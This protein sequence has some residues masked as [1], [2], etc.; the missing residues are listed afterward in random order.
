MD[1]IGINLTVNE[2]RR[3]LSFGIV[4]DRELIDDPEPLAEALRRCQAELL[5]LVQNVS[6]ETAAK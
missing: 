2:L 3:A 4:A 6:P 1:G 5:A